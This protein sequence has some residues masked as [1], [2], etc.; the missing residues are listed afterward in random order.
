MTSTTLTTSTTV[1]TSTTE[2]T[3]TT[4]FD[5]L[6]CDSAIIRPGECLVAG[7]FKISCNGCFR[8]GLINGN[9][10]VS[11]T[12]ISP[13]AAHFILNAQNRAYKLCSNDTSLVFLDDTNTNIL[14]Q[15]SNQAGQVYIYIGDD[16]QVILGSV[17]GPYVF[18]GNP[19]E[20]Y[21]PTTSEYTS[22]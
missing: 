1:S 22:K 3:S 21:K 14:T 6:I 2:K 10:V 16:S 11:S 8:M 5:P 15:G 12:L 18:Y 13:F 19:S 4:T 17:S 20:C 7:Q 9:L